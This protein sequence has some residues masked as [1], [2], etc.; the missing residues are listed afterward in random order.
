MQAQA[1]ASR[2]EQ[3]LLEYTGKKVP[4]RSVV[5][6]PGWYVNNQP[7]GVKTWV[8]NEKN[9]VGFIKHEDKKLELEEIHVLAAGLGRYVRDQQ[10]Q[11]S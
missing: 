9:L 3:I 4:V 6:F 7:K 10:K 5:L 2:L 11:H 1:A 8:M